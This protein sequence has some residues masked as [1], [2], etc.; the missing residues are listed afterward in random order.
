MSQ[1]WLTYQVLIAETMAS[2]LKYDPVRH[3]YHNV[4]TFLLVSK[5][6][7]GLTCWMLKTYP[8]SPKSEQILQ[9]LFSA[10]RFSNTL[11]CIALAFNNDYT[12]LIL[13]VDDYH[14]DFIDLRY[15]KH[16]LSFSFESTKD[17][18]ES[19]VL[20]GLLSIQMTNL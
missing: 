15:I 10:M 1:F 12:L 3:L 13:V 14:C 19:V 20:V 8:T 16:S 6:L 7:L 11:Q 17:Q 2:K 9:C 18:P 5:P 4:V